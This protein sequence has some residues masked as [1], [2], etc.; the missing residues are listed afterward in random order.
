MARKAIALALFSLLLLGGCGRAA[1]ALNYEVGPCQG[2]GA[3]TRQE[4]RVD[5][6]VQ[7]S[8]IQL[9][10]DVSYVCC[11]RITLHMEQ[12]DD[13]IKIVETNEGEICRCICAYH[14]TGQVG[15]LRPGTY[16]VQVWG[17]QYQDVHPLELLGEATV[18][19]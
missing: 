2:E 13:L 6:S 5:I 7:D 8:T 1:P 9:A 3:P 10:Q 15:G 16:R 11:A 14:I 18:N 17:V 4:N 12:E 19:L